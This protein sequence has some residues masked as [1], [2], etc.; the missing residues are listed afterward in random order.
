MEGHKVELLT[1]IKELKDTFDEYFKAFMEYLNG[2]II[3]DSE[4]AF[5]HPTLFT[6]SNKLQVAYLQMPD[7]LKDRLLDLEFDVFLHCNNIV[8]FYSFR[9]FLLENHRFNETTTIA[10][11]V[12]SELA[13]AKML[14][15][16]DIWNEYHKLPERNFHFYRGFQQQTKLMDELRVEYQNIKEKQHQEQLE[17]E[18]SES[19]DDTG[20]VSKD[21]IKQENSFFD[22]VIGKVEKTE[23]IVVSAGTIVGT[24]LDFINTL[25]SMGK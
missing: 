8:D 1:Q 5:S 14:I 11:R 21:F 18:V 23:K 6:L 20:K 4:Y 7:S 9:T 25:A 16:R 22:G 13:L 2:G 17:K 15:E 10:E 19:E 12:D 24:T 3:K